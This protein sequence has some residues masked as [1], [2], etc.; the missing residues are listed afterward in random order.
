MSLKGTPQLRKRLRALSLA[1]KPAGKAWADDTAK[2]MRPQVPFLTGR[3]RKSIKRKNATQKRATVAAHYSAFFVDKGPKP[4][5]IK[6][7]RARMLRF[8]AEGRTVFAR[9]VHHRGYRGRPFRQRA[10]R[11]ALR[12][13]PMTTAVI[14]AWNKAA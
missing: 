13:N 1:F 5:K 9:A 3:L 11:E 2:L 10:A 7:K 4:H 6:P 14:E 12:R 8:Q